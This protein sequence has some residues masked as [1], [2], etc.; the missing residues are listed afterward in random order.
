MTEPKKRKNV[1]RILFGIVVFVGYFAFVKF[2]P[3]MPHIQLPA[4]PLHEHPL[5]TF[6]AQDFYFTN[7]M[8][9]VLIAYVVILLIAWSIRKQI[10]SGKLVLDG[11]SGAVASILEGFYNMTENTA[12]KHARKI[13]PYFATIFLLVLFVNLQ[14]LLPTVDTVGI[15]RPVEEGHHG[16]LVEKVGPF[17]TIQE[18]G[19]SEGHAV[20]GEHVETLSVF[21][22]SCA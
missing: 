16:Y 2:K 13:F 6:A 15:L 8:T 9:S 1:N 3:F 19:E 10:K 21:S 4:E 17:N 18:M 7:T 22:P 14:E 20:E 11:I 5:F 12:G